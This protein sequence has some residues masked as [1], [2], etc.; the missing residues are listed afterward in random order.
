M[1]IWTFSNER[2]QIKLKNNISTK[3]PANMEMAWGQCL[4]IPKENGGLTRNMNRVE[5]TLATF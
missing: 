5:S 3:L 1:N 4:C 2:G